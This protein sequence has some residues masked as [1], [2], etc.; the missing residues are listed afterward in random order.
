MVPEA[1]IAI[2]ATQAPHYAAQVRDARF[3]NHSLRSWEKSADFQS[4]VYPAQ[5][6]RARIELATQGF[7]VLRS[8]NEL[9]RQQAFVRDSTNESRRFG[10]DLSRC[11]GTKVGTSGATPAFMVGVPG[12]E[13]ETSTLSVW[14]SNQL[15]YMPAVVYFLILI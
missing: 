5:M 14:R 15:S 1:P 3:F 9:P 6:P 4:G 10:P 2:G 12:F 13:P 7:S 8:T 11:I